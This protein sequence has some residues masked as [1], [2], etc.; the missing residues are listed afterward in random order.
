MDVF[1]LPEL[2]CYIFKYLRPKQRAK[3]MTICK[4]FSKYLLETSKVLSAY[5]D[6][7]NGGDINYKKL[8]SSGDYHLV[9]RLKYAAGGDFKGYYSGKS[10]DYDVIKLIMKHENP[11]NISKAI[12][13]G[14]DKK[15]NPDALT[16]TKWIITEYK[17]N[18]DVAIRIS[19]RYDDIEL[20]NMCVEHTDI[21]VDLMC[22]YDS[23]N[24][25]KHYIDNL[26]SE[27]ILLFVSRYNSLK[28]IKFMIGIVGIDDLYVPFTIACINGNIEI[29]KLLLGA[30][31]M[32]YN[33][34]MVNACMGG[35]ID[36]I[37]LMI[38]MGANDW[39]AGLWSAQINRNTLAADLMIAHG[40]TNSYI[41]ANNHYVFIN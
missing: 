18:Y 25:V 22:T 17:S 2:A 9:V 30:G 32:L 39:N 31:V 5:P 23:I 40:A 29:V 37:N 11:L 19:Y 20:F 14:V 16:V 38:E 6:A 13:V 34:G 10:C 8:Y 27:K 26:D 1:I 15:Y 24:I 35:H 21:Y 7:Y 41:D 36:I 33:L 3:L 28:I 4:H 12:L